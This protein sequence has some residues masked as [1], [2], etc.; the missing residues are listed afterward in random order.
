MQLFLDHPTQT[1][2]GIHGILGV[3]TR[4]C[5]FVFIRKIDEVAKLLLKKKMNKKERQQ[6]QN[7]L[8]CLFILSNY[9]PH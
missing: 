1:R 2:R 3:H 4:M 9:L 8:S 5:K 7:L 6:N